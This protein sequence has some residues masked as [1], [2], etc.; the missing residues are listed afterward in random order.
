MALFEKSVW[1]SRSAILGH[2]LRPSTSASTVEAKSSVPSSVPSLSENLMMSPREGFISV[3]ARRSFRAVKSPSEWIASAARAVP[4]RVQPPLPSAGTNPSGRE[5]NMLAASRS[6]SSAE[7]KSSRMQK[8][9]SCSASATCEMV[10]GARHHPPGMPAR[11][12]SR[13]GAWCC[14]ICKSACWRGGC[15]RDRYSISAMSCMTSS[16]QFGMASPLGS[17]ATICPSMLKSP[18]EME[19]MCRSFPLTAVKIS[20]ASLEGHPTSSTVGVTGNE[21]SRA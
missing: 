7:R 6:A 20:S 18:P 3:R 16:W 8:N 2:P 10:S 1:R 12:E 5:R 4:P 14:S 9:V 17:S 13:S 19:S 11:R 15:T 21:L